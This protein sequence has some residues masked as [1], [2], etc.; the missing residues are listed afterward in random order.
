[1]LMFRE[2]SQYKIQDEK[3]GISYGVGKERSDRKTEAQRLDIYA[4]AA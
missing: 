3:S 4:D 1:M 2:N